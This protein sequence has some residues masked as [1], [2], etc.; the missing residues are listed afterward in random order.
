MTD[1][2]FLQ[3]EQLKT[4]RKRAYKRKRV[5]FSAATFFLAG[6]A[7]AC[8]IGL[9]VAVILLNVKENN[10][11]LYLILTGSFAGGAA[12]FAAAAFG[13]EKLSSAVSMKE[14]DFR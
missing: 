11:T 10:Q 5:F 1:T 14:S 8:M 7:I 2:E 9:L 12:V 4:S 6:L 13:L 3:N